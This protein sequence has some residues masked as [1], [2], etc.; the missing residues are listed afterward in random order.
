MI[1]PANGDCSGRENDALHTNISDAIEFSAPKTADTPISICCLLAVASL[2]F[3]SLRI[4]LFF[5][6]RS[7]TPRT[8]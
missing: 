2:L 7:D 6:K 5:A 3:D 4:A 8:T 1:L